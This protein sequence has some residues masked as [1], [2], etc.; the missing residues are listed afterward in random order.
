MAG[1]IDDTLRNVP[2]FEEEMTYVDIA[3]F[4]RDVVME[5]LLEGE[6]TGKTGWDKMP[7]EFH[8]R[9]GAR[10]SELFIRGDAEEPHL[11]H[12]ITRNVL[13]LWLDTHGTVRDD[14]FAWGELDK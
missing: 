14:E 5:V 11:R 12:A 9:R 4:A 2:T 6:R 3:D 8:A 13:A 10:H 1:W 7:P